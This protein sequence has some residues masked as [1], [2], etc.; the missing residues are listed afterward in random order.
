[1][2]LQGT[3]TGKRRNGGKASGGLRLL[4]AGAGDFLRK[5]GAEALG[6][7]ALVLGLAGLLALLT[8][9][10]GDPGPNVATDAAVHN[11]LGIPG[12]WIADLLLATLGLAASLIALVLLGWA[13]RRLRDKAL[14]RWGLRLALLP[15]MLLLAAMALDGLP[16]PGGWAQAAGLGGF[17]GDLLLG[18]FN[19]AL[20]LLGPI[21]QWVGALLAALPAL[22]AFI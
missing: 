20:T 2:A 22:A 15:A 3:A 21:P 1:M 11:L 12:A 8:Y 19:R 13:W 17:V 7:V 10:P 4:P 9:H 5:R 14:P 6:G 18:H 16:R